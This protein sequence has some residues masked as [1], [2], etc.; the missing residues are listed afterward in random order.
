M[1]AAVIVA[2]YPKPVELT[3]LLERLRGQVERVC[4]ID[5]TP[6]PEER[7]STMLSPGRD[8]DF[9]ID[10]HELGHNLGVATGLNRGIQRVLDAGADYVL[11]CDQDS[12]PSPT[13]VS[14][15]LVATQELMSRGLQV[16]AVGPTFTDLHTGITF[17]F[18]SLQRGALIPTPVHP[19]SREPHVDALTLITSGSLI[20]RDIFKA[21]GL[22][23]DDL[24][25]DYV[26]IEWCLRARAAGFS[27]FGTG[28]AI[29]EHRMGEESLSVW[30]FGWRQETLYPPSRIYYRVRN[31]TALCFSRFPSLR[32]KLRSTWY[33]AGVVYSHVFFGGQRWQSLRMACRGLVDALRGHM[34]PL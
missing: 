33:M 25:I 32:W 7:A 3:A 20:A 13:M 31:Q 28:N 27:V 4:I 1:I 5:N 9:N 24:F 19:S 6:A 29:M 23:R 15:L 30:Y 17:P 16:A 12:L 10:I 21:V 2:Y 11:L 34:G 18:K 22:M 14:N 8:P 26:D